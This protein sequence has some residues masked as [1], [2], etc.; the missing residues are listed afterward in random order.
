MGRVSHSFRLRIQTKLLADTDVGAM[1][2]V[3]SS[4]NIARNPDPIRNAK[5]AISRLN[6]TVFLRRHCNQHENLSLIPCG[7]SQVAIELSSALCSSE[8]MSSPRMLKAFGSAKSRKIRWNP[9]P[10]PSA[11]AFLKTALAHKARRAIK[12]TRIAL[13]FIG[14]HQLLNWFDWVGER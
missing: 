13:F 5:E 9:S 6:Y 1:D 7:K 14:F 11:N 2:T 8:R 12:T 3:D 4:R 10:G